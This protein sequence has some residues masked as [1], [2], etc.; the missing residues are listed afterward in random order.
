MPSL[1]SHLSSVSSIS[2]LKL[3]SR[4]GHS[5]AL[6]LRLCLNF[7]IENLTESKNCASGINFINVPVFLFPTVPISSKSF[8][9]TLDSN[10]IKY[11]LASLLIQTSI[12][13]ERALTTEIPTP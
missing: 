5:T 4:P 9:L 12:E 1:K 13:L 10:F 6:D 2:F 3:T 7:F 11:C 8:D